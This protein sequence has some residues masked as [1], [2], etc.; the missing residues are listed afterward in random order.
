MSLF[1]SLPINFSLGTYLIICF[2]INKNILNLDKDIN[3]IE[4]IKLCPNKG[5]KTCCK[6]IKK[7]YV[8]KFEDS[9]WTKV[10]TLAELL[11]ALNNVP[12]SYMLVS[13]NTARGKTVLKFQY[14][15]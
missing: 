2:K 6:N 4:D 1:L 5:G 14:I 12:K 13:G 8:L 9:Q 7:N 3:D 15:F 11:K 10:N